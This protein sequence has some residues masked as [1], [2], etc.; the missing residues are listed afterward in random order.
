M[1]RRSHVNKM[2]TSFNLFII[3]YMYVHIA[4]C[5]LVYASKKFTN[6]KYVHVLGFRV[7][8][9]VMMAVECTSMQITYESS[10]IVET[11]MHPAR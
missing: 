6:F 5:L 11:C 7:Q 10:A 2:L 4:R 1:P 8:G 3:I 9:S